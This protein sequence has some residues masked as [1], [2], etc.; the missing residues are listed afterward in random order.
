MPGMAT[1]PL[2]FT[3]GATLAA[4]AL[5]LLYS[6]P[7]VNQRLA[8]RF[9]AAGGIVRGWIYPGETLPT[10]RGVAG[11]SGQAAAA[12]FALTR[13][14]PSPTPPGP[15][16][17]PAAA[18]TPTPTPLPEAVAL[19]APRWE[20]QDWNNCGP[21]A[22]ALGLRFYGWGG[23]QHDISAV[24]KP[25]RGDRNVNVE[26]LA[27]YVRTRAGWMQAEYRVG[28]TR[29][30]LQRL[31]AAGY[32][33]I[34]EKGDQVREGGGGWAG[35]YLL[36]TGYDDARGLYI[37]QD[38]Y[39]SA[40]RLVAYEALEAEWRAFNHVYL[41]VYPADQTP[42]IHALLG[43]DADIEANRLRA[44][45]EAEA[46]VAANPDDAYAWFNLGSNLTFFERYGEAGRAFDRALEIGLPWRFTLYQIGPYIS[47]FRSGRYQDAFDL[48][49]ATLRRT[50]KSEEALLWRGWSRHL[51]G[52]TPGALADF[53][54]ALAI[55]PNYEDAR[56][57]L[58]YLGALP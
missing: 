56:Y 57:A 40:D 36:V 25:D 4:A 27:Y 17:T 10:P 5:A 45:A 42:Q 39:R 51:L 28:G 38:P 15:T 26:E 13:T 23:D 54:A 20:F 2:W 46:V 30:T 9:D 44:L 35:H 58:R 29:A 19:P 52:D 3:L 33:V 22:L 55:N 18:P 53:H 16:R 21:A 14:P 43:E 32:P 50:P 8:W 49:D 37:T 1:R 41:I 24:L 47:F 6:L 34:I 31:L 12:P 7:P 11:T 48:A